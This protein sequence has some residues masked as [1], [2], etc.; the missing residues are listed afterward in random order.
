MKN[1]RNYFIVLASCFLF[2]SSCNKDKTV[3]PPAETKIG[4]T[5]DGGKIAYFFQ[6]GDP[7]YVEGQKHGIIVAFYDQSVSMQWYNGSFTATGGT[8][9][10][11]GTG[12]TNTNTIVNSQGVGTYAAKL[13]QD[14]AQDNHTD[15]Y[16]PSKDELNKVYLNKAAIG[17]FAINFYWSSSEYNSNRAWRQDFD[18]GAQN[19]NDKDFAGYV[20]AIRT[21]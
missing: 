1:L 18:N 5:Y 15:W 21:F 11:L 9:I 20:R 17:G 6:P 19:N 8:G 7:G 13:C 14:L 10:A 2:F 12:N 16:L 4:D 3:A